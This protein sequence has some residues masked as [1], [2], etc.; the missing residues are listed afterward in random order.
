M[1]YKGVIYVKL[2]K[3]LLFGAGVTLGLLALPTTHADADEVMVKSGDTLS[4]LAV[5]YNTT[6]DEIKQA[7]QLQSDLIVVG[8]VLEIGTQAT[9]TPDKYTVQS[10]DTLSEIAQT[11]N[12]SVDDLVNWNKLADANL[13]FVGQELVL[14]QQEVQKLTQVQES[15]PVQ[16]STQVQQPAQVQESNTQQQASTNTSSQ[17]TDTQAGASTNVSG[18][19]ADAKAWIA[20]RE[21]GSNYNA[22]NGQYIGK[23]QLTDIYLNGDYSPAN[24]ERVADQ[25]VYGRYGS[26]VNAKN[27]WL[28]HGWY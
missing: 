22:R 28:S 4:Q 1:I 10:G 18:V 25:Y 13:I 9:T 6:V 23:Y 3:E 16:Q 17:V 11:H 8:D 20:M 24:Q 19:E 14:A 7:N 2:H 12:V 21:S 26:W 27:F 15:A 5:D